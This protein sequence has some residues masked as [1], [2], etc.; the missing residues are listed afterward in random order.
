M[1]AIENNTD[2]NS[3][4]PILNVELDMDRIKRR[5][6]RYWFE[7][8][9]TELVVG[10]IF[11]L[12][13]LFSILEGLAAPGSTLRRITGIAALL[14]MVS[15]AWLG[16]PILRWL[17]RRLTYQRTGYVTYRKPDLSP[18]RRILSYGVALV[19]ALVAVLLVVLIINAFPEKTLVWIPLFEG[20]IIGGFLLYFGYI[21]GY[22]RFFFLGAY[23][24][25]LGGVLSVSGVDNLVGMGVFF[26]LTGLALIISGGI[27]LIIYLRKTR[28]VVEDIDDPR[29]G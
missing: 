26:L 4:K 1:S 17:K 2:A 7:D 28:P 19:F 10:C 12:I 29:D 5:S 15:G 27:V 16:R 20:I 6:L 21:S 24:I 9:F 18:G 25:L 13:G 11:A 14:L 3:D 8:G 23:A 22:S